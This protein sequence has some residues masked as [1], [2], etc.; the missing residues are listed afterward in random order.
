V[1]VYSHARADGH[2]QR[3]YG[4][5]LLEDRIID[6]PLAATMPGFAENRQTPEEEEHEV[7]EEP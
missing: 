5:F 2:A 4:D 1:C 3:Q 6:G 7:D